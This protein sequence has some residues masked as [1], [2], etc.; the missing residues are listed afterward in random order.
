MQQDNVAI[1]L[2]QVH[3]KIVLWRWRQWMQQDNVAMCCNKHA[4]IVLWRWRFSEH[5]Y[6]GRRYLCPNLPI[7]PVIK[8]GDD[9]G[10][11]FFA[12]L[13]SPDRPKLLQAS[14]SLAS[15]II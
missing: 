10:G 1:V 12:R 4:K 2:Q 14:L 6:L 5:F 13:L 7:I 8:R 3:A 9:Y 15:I 11:R